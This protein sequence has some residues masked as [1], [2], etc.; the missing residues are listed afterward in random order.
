MAWC[1]T[2]ISSICRVSMRKQAFS[3][4]LWSN[5]LQ[6]F[7]GLLVESSLS[8]YEIRKILQWLWVIKHILHQSGSFLDGCYKLILCLFDFESCSFG[9]LWACS[10]EGRLCSIESK[11]LLVNIASGFGR[12]LDARIEGAK[13]SARC[14]S[15]GR[16][17][18]VLKALTNFVVISRS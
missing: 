14:T 12:K 15:E 4:H 1:V 5:F 16:S 7:L 9:T 10:L 13:Q 6:N 2:V 17:T 3:T 18:Y 8:G 11:A